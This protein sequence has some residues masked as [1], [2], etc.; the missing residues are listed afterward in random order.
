MNKAAQWINA[1]N[2]N[3]LPVVSSARRPSFLKFLQR[4]PIFILAF[5][6]PV[7]RLSAIDATKGVID[8]W[9]LFQVGLL[10]LI[11]TR[12]IYRLAFAR[13]IAIPKQIRTILKLALLLGLLYLASAVYSPSR[14]VSAAYAVLN[15]LTLVCVIEFVADVYH[16]P[17]DWIQCLIHL[18]FISILLLAT[19]LAVLPFLPGIVLVHVEGAGIRLLG[20]AVAPLTLV[21]PVIAIVSA[22]NYLHGLESKGRSAFYFM[23]GMIATL[24][25][26]A[27]GAELA[28]FLSLVILGAGWAR[29]SR[30]STYFFLSILLVLTPILFGAAAVIGGGRIWSV[31]NRGQDAAGIASASGRIED[32]KFVIQYCSTHP[33]G[34]GYVAG[35]RMLFKE[36]YVLGVQFFAERIGNAHNAYMQTLADAGWLALG[37]YLVLLVKITLLGSRFAKKKSLLTVAS[38]SRPYHAMRCSLILL[39]FCLAFG[40]DSADCCVPLR[41]PYYLQNII[42]AI[43]LGISARQLAASST[44]NIGSFR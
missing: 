21:A 2:W 31:F 35:F 12:A 32:W 3:E 33:Q 17:P 20:G 25:T 22:Y 24:V 39:V 28:L 36:Y 8:L 14:L 6:P 5:G 29:T 44:R 10:L 11:A 16:D 18:R 27:R 15:F 43:I 23:V 13:S 9:S 19:V 37:V 30:R 1:D 42:I 7:L 38:E 41:E 4:Y 26:Q 34:M 40:M